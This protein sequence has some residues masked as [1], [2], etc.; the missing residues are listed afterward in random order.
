MTLKDLT[1][2]GRN[3]ASEHID[4]MSALEIVQLMNTEDAG[5]TPAVG[6]EA[7]S[8]AK[9]IEKITDRLSNGGRL[10]LIG[11]GAS[12]WLG[13]LE[14]AECSATF[15]TPPGLVIG[16]IAGGRAALEQSIDGAEDHPEFAVQD[17]RK[18]A[19]TERDVVVGVTASG[20]TP[21]VL[22][23]L[24]YARTLGA[25][26]IAISCNRQPDIASFSELQ[27]TPVV[28]SEII[29][30]STR[31]KAGTA[32]KMVL[33]M[34]TTGAMVLLGK[35]YRNLMVNVSRSNVKLK[36]RSQRIVSALAAVT[37]S[38]EENKILRR[39]GVTSRRQSCLTCNLPLPKKPACC[40]AVSLAPFLT[41]LNFLYHSLS[42]SIRRNRCR[43]SEKK[44]YG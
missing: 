11:A 15:G 19:L 39:C 10:I 22:G 9:A 18:A 14:A 16:L 34:L 31:L 1:T 4:S 43:S 42:H 6:R 36:E 32:T 27:I 23:G 29:T 44:S 26:S 28:G 38:E 20:R 21:Y 25:Y 13:M 3:P 33:N 2:E 30:G 41:Q 8:I 24:E 17:L 40:F 37:E 12:G 5:V 7:A 35:T